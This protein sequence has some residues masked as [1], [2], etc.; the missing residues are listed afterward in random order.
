MSC[1]H[2]S[3]IAGSRPHRARVTTRRL[4]GADVLGSKIASL[5]AGTYYALGILS[6]DREFPLDMD[7][8]RS[9]W[10][11]LSTATS[12]LPEL[13]QYTTIIG[14]IGEAPQ[15]VR[16]EDRPYRAHV[17]LE[18][19]DFDVRMESW[20]PTDTIRRAGFGRVLVNRRVLLT[21]ERGVSLA[22]LGGGEAVYLSGLFAPIPRYR[23][24]IAAR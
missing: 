18:A 3:P 15:F 19:L 8:L 23:W 7:A 12:A 14:R 1:S 2:L 13:R 24:G 10:A 9:A 22:A 5:P 20:L 6:P 11:R 21:L 4:Q 16:S 17:R